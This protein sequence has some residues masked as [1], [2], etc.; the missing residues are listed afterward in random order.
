MESGATAAFGPVI[1]VV[2]G[3]VLTL[4]V[5]TLSRPLAGAAS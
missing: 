2:G 1:S 5:I 3:G 4:V